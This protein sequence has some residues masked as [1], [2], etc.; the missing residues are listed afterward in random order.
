MNKPGRRNRKPKGIGKG[1]QAG[2]SVSH[3]VVAVKND[4]SSRTK[5]EKYDDMRNMCH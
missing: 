1:G 5:V 3:D 2:K 4:N